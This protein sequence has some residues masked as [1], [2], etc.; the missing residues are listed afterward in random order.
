[1]ILVRFH[2]LK[3]GEFVPAKIDI[4][5]CMKTMCTHSIFMKSTHVVARALYISIPID[6]IGWGSFTWKSSKE[7]QA[8]HFSFFLFLRVGLNLATAG[9]EG[10]KS[11][12]SC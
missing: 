11:T 5:N 9:N 3:T 1:M 10:V 12:C 8:K 4:P 2:L 7:L 6:I